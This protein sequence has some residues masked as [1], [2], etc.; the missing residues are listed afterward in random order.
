MKGTTR[1]RCLTVLAPAVW[2][3]TYLITTELLPP[4]RPMFA[5]LVRALPAGLVLL[6][7]TR[8]GLP[9]GPWVGRAF[10]LGALNIGLFF[11][12][13]FGAAYRLPGGI[14][15]MIGSVQPL[16]VIMISAA[17]LGTPIRLVH[18]GA[19][20]LGTFG[21]AL[22][23]ARSAVRLD[24]V[25]IAAACAAAC[26]MASGIVLTKKWGRP[27]GLLVFTSWQLIAGGL[28]LLI[29]TLIIEGVPGHITAA[30]AAGYAYLS[31]IGACF[32]YVVW[33][34]GI[35][36]LSASAASFLSLLSPVVAATLGF[37]VL[38]QDLTAWQ[39]TGMASILTAIVIG[40]LPSAGRMRRTAVR[41]NEPVG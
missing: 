35:E 20:L 5:G 27:V 24:P 30:N 11:A 34:R 18:V 22:L 28:I 26:S 39:L 10:V 13:L 40:Q 16:I 9:R 15:A 19:S 1:E 33:F 36:Q 8:G 3:T 12:L 6:A 32:A 2:G 17:V 37:A 25:G 31:L 23:L 29:P 38:G 14:A 41:S 4:G 21:V 7:V